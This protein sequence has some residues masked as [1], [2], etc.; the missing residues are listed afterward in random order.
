[1]QVPGGILAD[2][3]GLRKTGTFAILW[4]SAFTALTAFA[5][6][7]IS[8]A[9][10]RL[11]FGLGEGP[12]FPS[13]GAACYKWFHHDEKGKAS[14]SILGGTFFG[15]VVGP[16]LTVALMSWLGWQ[17]VFIAF[18]IL[19]A[20][21]AYAWHRYTR[22]DPKDCPYVSKE[23]VE[24][25][26]E[27]RGANTAKAVAPWKKL[28][29]NHRFWAV[30]LQFLVVDYIMYV[31][32]AWLPMFLTEVYG[33]NLKSMGFWTAVPWI[34]LTFMV[35]FAGWFSDRLA[36]GKNSERQY[37]MR[38]ATAILG[39][40]VTSVGLYAASQMASVEAAI[41]WMT[42]ALGAL[43]FCMS[44]TW[45]SV[46]SLGGRF[47]GSVSGWINLWGNIGGVLAPTVTAF[48]VEAYGWNDA[49]A[50]TALFGALVVVCW[51]VIKP[52]KQLVED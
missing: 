25:I 32:L 51:L 10:V 48:L 12:V 9:A 29:K 46:M 5:Q 44:A 16:V 33:L 49:F 8:F 20:V 11:A 18:G 30:G 7:K 37:T 19:G 4:W 38:S 39:I 21:V 43:G 31:F 27:A 24:Y 3:F 22:D 52:G 50:I 40:V 26:N 42:V 47:S 6:G 23:E 34:A 15:P 41:F 36:M 28:L 14:S 17:G 2:R 35:F 13:L 1:M 45:S